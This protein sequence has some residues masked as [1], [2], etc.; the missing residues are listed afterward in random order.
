MEE[1]EDIPW[2]FGAGRKPKDIPLPS[3]EAPKGSG[4]SQWAG[5]VQLAQ[6]GES[7]AQCH[8]G[9]GLLFPG[10]GLEEQHQEGVAWLG[11]SAQDGNSEAMCYLGLCYAQG[12][13]VPQQEEE[14]VLWWNIAKKAGNPLGKCLWA[15]SQ[16]KTAP[17]LA[18]EQLISATQQG[19]LLGA[20]YTGLSFLAQVGEPQRK[21][22]A[23]DCIE[24]AAEGGFLPGQQFLARMYFLGE[25]GMVVDYGEVLKWCRVLAGAG[26]VSAMVF[27]GKAYYY[28]SYGLARRLEEAVLW[29][30]RGSRLED[31]SSFY[32][33]GLCY[34]QGYGK[35]ELVKMLWKVAL[36]GGFDPS[37]LG[38]GR[39][40]AQ[41]EFCRSWQEISPS[42]C[43]ELPP[44]VL[45]S[46]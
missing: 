38:E 3:Q 8:L 35:E 14:A 26:D 18:Q 32:Y 5:Y 41:W 9:L 31:A 30:E 7:L 2:E 39:E 6:E 4:A 45:R 40:P 28:G 46:L 37:T 16:V 20:Y 12:K 22:L 36:A 23:F 42:L 34:Q 10:S 43:F 24:Y 13:G 11:L 15:S 17:L 44:G 21:S 19:S 27:L 29:F 33:L 1:K 25:E